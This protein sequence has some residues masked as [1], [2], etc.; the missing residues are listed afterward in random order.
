MKTNAETAI[1]RVTVGQLLRQWRRFRQ[2]SQLSLALDANISQR[3]LSFIESGRAQPSRDMLQTLVRA[4]DLPLR[5]RND[6]FT[7]AGYAP[8]YRETGW[9]APQMIQ[10]RKALE[11][12]LE[13][14]EPY[15]AVVMDRH[16][17]MVN[18]NKSASRFFSL[19]LTPDSN[20]ESTN[21]LR[22]IFD[23]NRLRPFVS[24]WDEVAEAL[25]QRVHREAVGG[26]HDD[27]TV[28]LL[29]ALLS[30]PGVP[31]KWRVPDCTTFSIPFLPVEF[32][33]GELVFKYFSTVTTLGTPQDITLQE[34]R[35][36]CFFPADRETEENTLVLARSNPSL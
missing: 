30:Y 10:V 3:H 13:R 23:P 9:E 34:I 31:Q 14:Q 4:L 5:E 8:L 33:K 2:K 11:F 29:E 6:F 24:N 32:R 25:I 26:I 12:I 16:W 21:V 20:S 1:D 18:A 35:I 36:E 28:R 19:F 17:N 22:L 7:A 15:P 27:E